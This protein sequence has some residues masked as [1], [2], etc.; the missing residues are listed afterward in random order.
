MK[1]TKILFAI[2]IIN[3]AGFV[4]A[5]DFVPE[6][7][8]EVQISADNFILDA[9]DTGGDIKLTF[10]QSLNKYLQWNVGNS[11]FNLSDTIE[12]DGGILIAGSYS[13]KDGDTGLNGQVLSSTI[14]GT[15]W[16]TNSS[17]PI[18]FISST[19]LKINPSTSKIITIEGYNFTP[20]TSV[21]IPGFDGTIN[22]TTPL[23][24]TLLEINLT[25]GT[26]QTTY[27]I[28][29]SNNGVLNTEWS[30]NGVNILSVEVV[31]GTGP[32]GTYTESFETNFGQW[33]LSTGLDQDWRRQS[34]GTPS[35]NTGPNAA[36]NGSTYVY[37]ETSTSGTGYP[38]MTFGIETEYFN[39]A[40]SIS[41]DYH[42]FGADMGNLEVQYKN[43]FNTWITIFTLSGQQQTNQGDAYINKFIDLTPY[44]LKAIRFFYTSGSNYTG[45]CAI[46]NVQIISN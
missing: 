12:I 37:T 40:Q 34:N 41:F 31:S 8:T 36:S 10:G 42:M 18:P 44:E 6:G 5:D 25:A 11:R 7:E 16:V 38:N 32:A 21:S 13:D 35:G 39:I 14:T 9:D 22:S 20:T 17:N 46:D 23:S 27:D 24:S 43:S 2:I 28:I 26:T 33:T 19:N 4:F 1:F 15:D 45:D 29:L 30:G 3:F